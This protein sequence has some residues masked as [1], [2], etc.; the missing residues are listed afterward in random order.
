MQMDVR[1]HTILAVATCLVGIAVW[2]SSLWLM[3]PPDPNYS[4]TI[5]PSLWYA[6]KLAA[7]VGTLQHSLFPQLPLLLPRI[8]GALDQ[9]WALSV[10]L[11]HDVLAGL[12]LVCGLGAIGILAVRLSS[13]RGYGAAFVA[14]LAIVV[15]LQSWVT[16]LNVGYPLYVQYPSHLL[17][18]WGIAASLFVWVIWITSG[19][20][21][22]NLLICAGLAGLL[23]NLHATYG[24]I[25]IGI[26][27]TGIS[28]EAL[29]ARKLAPALQRI[30]SAIFFFSLG[31][32][33]QGL[34]ILY[35]LPPASLPTGVPDTAWWTLMSFRK[36]FHIYLWGPGGIVQPLCWILAFWCALIAALSSRISAIYTYRLIATGVAVTIFCAIAYAA[37]A[38]VPIPALI[39]AVLSRSALIPMA[40]IPALAATLTILC[41]R[42]WNEQQNTLNALRLILASLTSALLALP[43]ASD[44][45]KASSLIALVAT[46]ILM[47]LPDAAPTV[48]VRRTT[49]LPGT[50]LAV[51]AVAAPFLMLPAK[52]QGA[53]AMMPRHPG[54][55]WAQVTDYVRNVIPRD[56]IVLMPPYPYATVSSRHINPADYGYMGYSVYARGLV[57][58]EINQI[59]LLLK[60]NL[61][62]FSPQT[63]QT[64]VAKNGQILCVFEKGYVKLTS[65]ISRLHQLRSQYPSLHYFVAI[66]PGATPAQWTCGP[67][68]TQTLDLPRVFE[69]DTY[70]V[71]QLSE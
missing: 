13:A 15:F 26:I 63:I 30:V 56:Q 16:A 25:V 31:A 1:L 2:G 3:A 7:P 66:K 29:I 50:A 27:L 39:G 54:T 57:A 11:A 22:V 21:L 64:Y 49:R 5:A 34:L 43:I 61:L 70:V 14:I 10:E 33:P 8:L 46:T 45:V 60:I 42:S 35:Q 53:L 55:S 44:F 18:S 36:P 24:L 38:I 40:A 20:T 51:L 67:A 41:L 65:D 52:W 71:Y 62:N 68:E 28:I 17:G 32:L 48:A 23:T 58:L 12:F 69:N 37:F 47:Y 9:S 59:E 4:D 19:Q 6:G